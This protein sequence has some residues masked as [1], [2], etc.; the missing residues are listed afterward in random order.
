MELQIEK[1]KIITGMGF[2]KNNY[3]EKQETEK[4][5]TKNFRALDPYYNFTFQKYC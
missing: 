2:E 4:T 5:Y 1:E 3:I